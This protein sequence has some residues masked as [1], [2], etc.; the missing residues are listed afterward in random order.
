MEKKKFISAALSKHVAFWKQGIDQNTT[1][2]MKMVLYVEYW[3]DILLHLSKLLPPQSST[4]LEGFG[5]QATG[6]LIMLGPSCQL[7]WKL[8][9]QKT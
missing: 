2:A 9:M 4:L 8:L 5:L 1:Y 6:D 3:E 7:G